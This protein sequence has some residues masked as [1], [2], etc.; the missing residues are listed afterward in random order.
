MQSLTSACQLEP[1]KLV[2]IIVME[3]DYSHHNSKIPSFK[4]HCLTMFALLQLQT[5]KLN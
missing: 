1:R 4:V 3:I 5:S 2:V